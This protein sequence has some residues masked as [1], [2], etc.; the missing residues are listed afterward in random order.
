MSPADLAPREPT[1]CTPSSGI[2]HYVYRAQI[3]TNACGRSTDR[4]V[5]GNMAVSTLSV[6]RMQGLL[7]P[8]YGKI[9]LPARRCCSSHIR[10][11]RTFHRTLTTAAASTQKERSGEAGEHSKV[12]PLSGQR[13]S[14]CFTSSLPCLSRCM[15]TERPAQGK[16]FN[17]KRMQRTGRSKCC[18]MEVSN[19]PIDTDINSKNSVSWTQS[20]IWM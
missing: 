9:Q 19:V 15:T 5:T 14:N 1:V 12:S 18:M 2:L 17:H 3:V 7:K 8:F 6:G 4:M 16:L 20:E 10:Y 11:T 13:V